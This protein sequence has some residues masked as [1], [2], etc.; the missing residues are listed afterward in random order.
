M[1]GEKALYSVTAGS[2]WE[3]LIP[4]SV[5]GASTPVKSLHMPALSRTSLSG[6]SEQKHH[7]TVFS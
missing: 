1:V 5:H 2:S 6:L 3:G 7:I 4:H